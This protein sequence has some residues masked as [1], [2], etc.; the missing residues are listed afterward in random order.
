MPKLLTEFDKNYSYLYK[1]KM[2]LN[3]CYWWDRRIFHNLGCGLCHEEQ[4]AQLFL[5]LY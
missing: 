5:Y 3:Y 1:P 2:V 4:T